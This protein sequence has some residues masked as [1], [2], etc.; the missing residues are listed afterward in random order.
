MNREDVDAQALYSKYCTGK[1]LGRDDNP[2]Q[3]RL[4]INPEAF[5]NQDYRINM[6]K[7]E[8]AGLK[9]SLKERDSKILKLEA[10][11]HHPG[12]GKYIRYL[13]GLL[14]RNKIVAESSNEYLTDEPDPATLP[15]M[16]YMSAFERNG[17]K[18]R[19]IE[20]TFAVE[21]ALNVARL[22]GGKE[23]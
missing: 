8:I 1:P 16:G 4:F 9:L 13:Q 11:Q 19:A 14:R 21:K 5:M 2:H 22:L 15:R 12:C 7:Q 17:V 20:Y 3:G 18:L 23:Y 6:L 10:C